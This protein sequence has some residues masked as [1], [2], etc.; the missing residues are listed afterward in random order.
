MA[1]AAENDR[2]SEDE[3]AP[4]YVISLKRTR[5]RRQSIERQLRQLG[6]PYA[7]I[8][9]VDGKALTVAE[10]AQYSAQAAVAAIRRELVPKRSAVHSVISRCTGVCSRCRQRRV[11]LQVKLDFCE[12]PRLNGRARLCSQLAAVVGS[13][14]LSRLV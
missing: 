12:S 2:R 3:Q 13:S 7:V 10:R 6:L 8:D 1:S 5:D 4:T 14:L 9:A 11:A